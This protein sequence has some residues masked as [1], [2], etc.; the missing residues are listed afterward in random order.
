MKIKFHLKTLGLCMA[1][2]LAGVSCKREPASTVATVAQPSPTQTPLIKVEPMPVT[3][4]LIDALFSEDQ[5]FGRDLMDR[6]PLTD[7]QIA[8]VRTI[9][10]VETGKLDESAGSEQGQS[11]T[12]AAEYAKQKLVQ[13]IGE[14]KAEKFALIVQ[15]HSNSSV[16]LSKI[17]AAPEANLPYLAASPLPIAMS[18]PSSVVV[19]GSPTPTPGSVPAASPTPTPSVL[20]GVPV[21]TR[22]IVNAPA[23]RM[24]AFENGRLVKSYLITIG[25]P[26]F[27]I[28]YGERK[29]GSIIFNPTWTPPDEPWVESSNKV[30]VG[31]RIAAGDK[32]NPLGALK[33]PVGMP[34]LIHGGKRPVQIGKFGSHGCVGLTDEQAKDFAKHL[35]VLGGV[36]LNDEQ[37]EAFRKTPNQT[38]LVKLNQEIPVEF[39]Y[40]TIIVSD[41][42][43]HIYRDVYDRDTNTEENLRLVL[44]V[45]GVSLDDFSAEERRQ[46]VEALERMSHPAAG[47]SVDANLTELEKKEL[48]KKQIE[49]RKLSQRIQAEQE[50]IIDVAALVGKGYPAP[51]DLNDGQPPAPVESLVVPKGKKAIPPKKTI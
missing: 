31:Q 14:E 50:M 37:I 49:S 6:V 13:T 24:D 29:A 39:R 4:P 42:K 48:K 2:V 11:T 16:D 18:S 15:A 7:G 17:T 41:G 21:D 20:F 47:K 10:R 3:M 44:G 38:K 22:V 9:A 40:D 43:L 1:V 33:I 26:A 51:V 32:L 27:P 5:T 19:N 30:K 12:A 36:T 46:A 45:Y 25:Y 35:A 8:L 23:H 34:S 28:P